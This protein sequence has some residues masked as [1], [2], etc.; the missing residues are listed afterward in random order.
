[1]DIENLQQQQQQLQ[2]QLQQPQYCCQTLN[3]QRFICIDCNSLTLTNTSKSVSDYFKQ[4]HDMLVI[5]EHKINSTI[6]DRLQQTSTNI[7]NIINEIKNINNIFKQTVAADNNDDL[8]ETDT[9]IDIELVKSITS[10]TSLDQ[11]IEQ[12]YPTTSSSDPVIGITDIEL[13]T[14]VQRT[15][16]TMNTSQHQLVRPLSVQIDTNRLNDINDQLSLCFQLL[17]DSDKYTDELENQV[18]F[19]NST[20]YTLFSP[21]T[22]KWTLI[23]LKGIDNIYQ[24]GSSSVY[25]RGNIYVFGTSVDDNPPPTYSVFSVV[26]GQ[27]RHAIPLDG[28]VDPDGFEYM[29]AACFDGDKL[30]YLIGHVTPGG[31]RQSRVY[32]LNIDNPDHLI[33]VGNLEEGCITTYLFKHFDTLYCLD[34][35]SD[36]HSI[37]VFDLKTKEPVHWC[38]LED[39]VDACTLH[40]DKLYILFVGGRLISMSLSRKKTTLDQSTELASI[41]TITKRKDVVDVDDVDDDDDD[42]LNDQQQQRYNNMVTSTSEP[43][44]LLVLKG[45]DMNYKYSIENDTWSKIQVQDMVVA[46]FGWTVTCVISDKPRPIHT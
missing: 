39:D 33:H 1:M 12:T 4:L 44:T 9:D 13:L 15:I 30:I 43:G 38:Y 6:N 8:M 21:M 17:E 3:E 24:R 37:S 23:G 31:Y 2:Q 35:D 7:H 27:W 45:G 34:N 16:Q 40:E 20:S 28:V 42:N 32:S 26:D 18:M 25:A 14:L 5:E 19:I 41:T 29:S 36:H 11:F 10:C 22:N 46:E